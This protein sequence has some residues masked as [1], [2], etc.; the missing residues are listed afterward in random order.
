VF[1]NDSLGWRACE[2][3]A[4]ITGRSVEDVAPRLGF[5]PQYI[6]GNHGAE[7]PAAA[8]QLDMS[9]S[10]HS[11]ASLAANA[12]QLRNAGIEI[13]DKVIRSRCIPWRPTARPRRAHRSPV[14]RFS[15]RHC[16]FSAANA[17]PMSSLPAAP[18]KADALAALVNRC[19]ADIRFV[20]RRRRHDEAVFMRADP[21]W[22][23][24]RIGRDDPMSKADFFLDSHA[25]IA[26]CW[27][28]CWKS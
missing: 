20:C 28:S 27:R 13:E 21:T 8:Q 14:A 7:D 12:E 3:V 22:L 9:R 18:D 19:G 24:V 2:P 1:R 5:E 23:T 4:V 26:R 15:I 17:S 6:V 16:T 25:E 11:G 10:N